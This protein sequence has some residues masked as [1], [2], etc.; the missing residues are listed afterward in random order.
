M[1]TYYL[2][3]FFQKITTLLVERLLVIYEVLINVFFRVGMFLV[4]NYQNVKNDLDLCQKRPQFEMNL[5]K[6]SAVTVSHYGR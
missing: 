6:F 5:G 1:L 4:C 3:Y 2:L